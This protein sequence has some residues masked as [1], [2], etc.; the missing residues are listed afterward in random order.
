LCVGDHDVF[1][2]PTFISGDQAVFV[3]LMNRPDGDAEL[4]LR[5][6]EGVLSLMETMPELNEYKHTSIPR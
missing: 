1:G 4:A 5:T 2:V 6:I 3:R